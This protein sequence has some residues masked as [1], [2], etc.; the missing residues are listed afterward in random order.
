M[1]E[2]YKDI[3][4]NEEVFQDFYFFNVGYQECTSA[5]FHGPAIR[6]HFLVHYVMSGKGMFRGKNNQTYFLKAGDFFLIRPDE[7]CYYEADEQDPWTYYWLGFDGQKVDKI[8]KGC[9]IEKQTEVGKILGDLLE[10]KKYFKQLLESD[11]FTVFNRLENYSHFFKLFNYLDGGNS[12]NR[13]EINQRIKRRYG[14]SFMLHVQNNYHKSDLT[15]NEIAKSMN[16]NPS[17]LSQVIKEEIGVTP[18]DYLKGVRLH[19]ASV[20][21]EVGNF[22]VTEISEM[23]GYESLQSFSRVFK[24]RFGQAPSLYKR[25]I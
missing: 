22:T 14:E 2:T 16:L 15:I 24:E 9:H 19:E 5:H 13:I 7:L 21:L 12:A 20:L 8:L 3:F 4:M 11:H 18:M 17:Y 1:E 6:K 23:V 25:G 10:V